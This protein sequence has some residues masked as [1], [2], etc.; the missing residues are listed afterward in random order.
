MSPLSG[1]KRKK[2]PVASVY[3]PVEREKEKER[4]RS[5]G[6]RAR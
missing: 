2:G 4:F 1:K 3:E 6:L 5:D